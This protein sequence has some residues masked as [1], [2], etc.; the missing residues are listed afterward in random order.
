MNIKCRGWE[1]LCACIRA[2]YPTLKVQGKAV[3][4]QQ[5]KKFLLAKGIL[6]AS[7]KPSDKSILAQWLYINT[8][9]IKKPD[10][11]EH[12][13]IWELVVTKYGFDRIISL[14]K[15]RRVKFP[16]ERE[17]P[18]IP[19]LTSEQND[20][21][22]ELQSEIKSN[23]KNFVIVGANLLAI[24]SL[25]KIK[26][27][28]FEEYVQKHFDFDYRRAL[29]FMRAVETISIICKVEP[30]ELKVNFGSLFK[31]H[32]K[33]KPDDYHLK[34]LRK[35]LRLERK[36]APR[37]IFHAP[38]NYARKV[39]D[40]FDSERKVR[41][42][43]GLTRLQQKELVEE[44]LRAGTA[45]E[46]GIKRYAAKYKPET[47]AIKSESELDEKKIQSGLK[48]ILSK[49]NKLASAS[50]NGVKWQKAIEDIEALVQSLDKGEDVPF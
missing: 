6:D 46:L 28:L 13:K 43:T 3:H 33:Q 7:G 11:T 12:K 17:I 1:A 39:L 34:S 20:E 5:L 36:D 2:E 19:Q 26:G 23:I 10:G 40:I 45:T 37:S 32:D 30:D 31:G 16:K 24:K 47:Q 14:L 49:L 25:F 42:I 15:G 50:G 18:M 8:K 9:L 48:F 35:N 4:Y 27:A 22:E 44:V 38:A 41:A 29:Q 21:L